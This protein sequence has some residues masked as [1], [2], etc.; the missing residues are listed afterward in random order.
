MNDVAAMRDTSSSSRTDGDVAPDADA[1]AASAETPACSVMIG[2][3]KSAAAELGI[4]TPAWGEGC[5]IPWLL[6]EWPRVSCETASE[7][8]GVSTPE[9]DPGPRSPAS[10]LGTP[11]PPP[12][13]D[14][15]VKLPVLRCATPGKGITL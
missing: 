12:A 3:R 10:C 14:G 5:R 4:A 8:V 15:G 7:C 13:R 2:R 1:A 9:I 6:V 11:P